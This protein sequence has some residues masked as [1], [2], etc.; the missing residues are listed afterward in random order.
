[1]YLGLANAGAN[2]SS[3]RYG[4]ES[5]LSRKQRAGQHN[6][7]LPMTARCSHNTVA[8]REGRDSVEG[9]MSEA[10]VLV[11][12]YFAAKWYFDCHSRDIE[13]F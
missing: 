1:M 8:G 13:I 6:H 12:V 7:Q 9:I 11:S 3:Y 10:V 4:E 5:A 2:A